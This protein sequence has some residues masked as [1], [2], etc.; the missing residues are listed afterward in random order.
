MI[1]SE[2]SN[3]IKKIDNNNNLNKEIDINLVNITT[4]VRKLATLVKYIIKIKSYYAKALKLLK[5]D[6]FL[7]YNYKKTYILLDNVTY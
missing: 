2:L 3:Q 7:P 6:G 4:K 1:T 5:K